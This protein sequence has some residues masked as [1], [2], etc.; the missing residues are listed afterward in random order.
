MR[1]RIARI[2]F[3]IPMIIFAKICI[4]DDYRG[5]ILLFVQLPDFKMLDFSTSV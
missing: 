2:F 3:S 4:P 1:Q 5:F